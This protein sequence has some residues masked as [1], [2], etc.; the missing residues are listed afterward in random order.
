LPA[1][2]ATGLNIHNFCTLA[3]LNGIY[4]ISDL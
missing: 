1:F 3:L 4:S 2:W